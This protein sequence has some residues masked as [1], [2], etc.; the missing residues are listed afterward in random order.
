MRMGG[1]LSPFNLPSEVDWV[2]GV[3]DD[4]NNFEIFKIGHINNYH[5]KFA[6]KYVDNVAFEAMKKY[7]SGDYYR[8]PIGNLAKG[9]ESFQ[10]YEV[11]G[12]TRDYKFIQDNY[13]TVFNVLVGINRPHLYGDLMT[14][15]EAIAIQDPNKNPGYGMKHTTKE[16][17][18]REYYDGLLYIYNNPHTVYDIIPVWIVA[19]KDEIR[20]RL[21]LP[22]TF[23]FP[24]M[25]F[26]ML[27]QKYTKLSNISF[28][29]TWE[30]GPYCIGMSI[31]QDWPRLVKRWTR[32]GEPTHFIEWDGKTFDASQ[33]SMVRWLCYHIR[34]Q[35]LRE[36]MGEDYTTEMSNDFEHW[37]YWCVNRLNLLF[38]GELCMTQQGM[39]S[40]DPNTS[41][42]NSIAH[43]AQL[44]YCWIRHGYSP[45]KFPAFIQN[46]GLSI[47]GDDGCATLMEEDESYLTFF[48]ALPTLWNDIF[49][50]PLKLTMHDKLEDLTFLGRRSSASSGPGAVIPVS[51]DTDRL[52]SSIIYKKSSKH[53]LLADLQQLSAYQELLSA[54]CFVDTDLFRQLLVDFDK[55]VRLFITNIDAEYVSEEE[56]LVIERLKRDIRTVAWVPNNSLDAIKLLNTLS[57]KC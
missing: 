33:P 2:S 12:E 40:G 5:S 35:C 16:R 49:G 43:L 21:K 13:D 19:L 30:D 42:D 38:D 20:S 17:A 54:Y 46:V 44:L 14:D 57:F 18:I 9:R 32:R 56:Q 50:V 6:T 1:R 55:C 7:T 41:V 29:E 25:W 48:K 51:S 28:Q 22:R 47:F 15:L 34:D 24:P 8:A 11:G 27:I 53:T 39:G 23:Q 26:G 31:P 52:I 45:W 4:I 10:R 37:F 36:T 3:G